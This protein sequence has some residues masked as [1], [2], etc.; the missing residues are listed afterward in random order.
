VSL[1]REMGPEEEAAVLDA[2]AQVHAPRGVYLKRRPRE[3]RVEAN[4][5][6]DALAPET[7][8]RGE[9]LEVLDALEG[10]LRFRIRPAQGLSV[11]LYLDMREVRGWLRERAR[12]A[13]VL[14]LFAYTCGFSVYGRAGGA[15]R[16]LNLDASRR[17]LDWGVENAELNGQPADRYDY[18]AGDAFDWLQRLA[19]KGEAFDVVV[20][21]PPGFATTRDSRFSAARDYPRLAAACAERVRPGGTLLACCNVAQLSAVRF[22]QLVEQ[23]AAQAGRRL[24]GLTLLTQSPVDF[25]VPEGTEPPLKVWA[26]TVR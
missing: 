13:T 2:V 17:V 7:P 25:P 12:G 3:A 6:R 23:G 9:A 21:D 20:A 5:R 19:R 4:T 8:A 15:R 11:G 24:T 18:V 16:V 10:G 14:N 1:Y 26:A 22:R